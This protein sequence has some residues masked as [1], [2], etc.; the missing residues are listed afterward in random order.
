MSNRKLSLALSKLKNEKFKE[1]IDFLNEVIILFRDLAVGDKG[2]W[3]PFQS[4][5]ILSTMTVI[6]LSQYLINDCDFLFLLTSRLTQDCL[7]NLF[8][9]VRRKNIIPNAVQNLRII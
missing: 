5:V 7:E 2:H 8:S 3:K 9:A 1:V 6:D 4:A